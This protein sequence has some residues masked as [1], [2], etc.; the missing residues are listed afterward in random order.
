MER[1]RGDRYAPLAV[2]TLCYFATRV[3]PLVISPLVPDITAALDTTSG[4]IGT[5]MTCF[6]AAYALAQV[7]SGILTDRYGHRRLIA[8]VLLV[9]SA[10][11]VVLSR[12][13][14]VLV[15][16]GVAVALGGTLGLYYNAGV[17]ALDDEFDDTGWTLG[18]HRVG[19]QAAG[20]VVPVVAAAI[21]SWYSWRTGLL[22]GAI[23]SL[24]AAVLVIQFI[25]PTPPR[26]STMSTRAQ[27][28]QTLSGL[29]AGAP[30]RSVTALAGVGEFVAVAN[31]T[32]LP[33]FLITVHGIDPVLAG[34]LFS[35][36]FLVVTGTH[37]VAG[38]CSDRFRPETV[39]VAALAAGVVSH[40]LL[41]VARTQ[42]GAI[43]GVGL[44]GLTLGHSVPLQSKLLGSV[45]EERRANVFGGFR[46]V[47]V[48]IGSLGGVV[49][50]TIADQAGWEV[51]YAC[52]T[53]LLLAALI[54]LLFSR[55]VH[56]RIRRDE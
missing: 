1:L 19:S 12:A 35:M 27:L 46:T 17:L 49:T 39:V 22:L 47:Y 33:T 21:G 38:W 32:F 56:A 36:Y 42:L 9:G 28:E 15:F 6:W 10:G 18:V 34:G 29:G 41:V 40:G 16:A 50:G 52:L 25:E 13:P 24:P 4:T 11:S 31:L 48:L 7:P 54:G 23:A 20:L 2:Y 44:A 51:A 37:P 5:A 43:V 3:E 8:G 14:S 26:G 45:A 53:A 55:V 30:I